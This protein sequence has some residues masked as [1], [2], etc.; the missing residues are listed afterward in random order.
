[1]KTKIIKKV[2]VKYEKK[3]YSEILKIFLINISY[4]V[5]RWKIIIFDSF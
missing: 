3:V 2:N 5:S 4:N 1:M